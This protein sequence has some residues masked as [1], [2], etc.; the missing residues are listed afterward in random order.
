MVSVQTCFLMFLLEVPS[1]SKG[2]GG[3]DFM[4]L[5]PAHS[6]SYKVFCAMQKLVFIQKVVA[7]LS[8]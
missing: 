5:F 7:G 2:E 3:G 6:Y 1:P 8:Q 4:G